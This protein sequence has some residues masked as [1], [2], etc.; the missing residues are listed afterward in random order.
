MSARQCKKRGRGY[1]NTCR[2][3]QDEVKNRTS[4]SLLTCFCQLCRALWG[5]RNSVLQA[6]F[7]PRPVRQ[8]SFL[9]S[10]ADRFHINFTFRNVCRSFNYRTS[11]PENQPSHTLL[12]TS[13]TFLLMHSVSKWSY[14]AGSG[15]VCELWGCGGQQGR[16]LCFSRTST[17]SPSAC[18]DTPLVPKVSNSLINRHSH[19]TVVSELCEM[20]ENISFGLFYPQNRTWKWGKRTMKTLVSSAEMTDG[21]L[22]RRSGLFPLKSLISFPS[23]MIRSDIGLFPLPNWTYE[24]NTICWTSC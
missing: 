20:P 14:N 9:T 23:S 5:E 8:A 19:Y 17:G 15:A 2:L 4:L 3:F 21:L 7:S 1:E 10:L 12:A 11:T 16:C 22:W 13:T 24:T 6:H 18:P